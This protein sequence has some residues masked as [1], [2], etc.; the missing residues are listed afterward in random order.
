MALCGSPPLSG[1]AGHLVWT[2]AM[3]A[4]TAA[5]C[6]SLFPAAAAAAA[7]Y[8]NVMLNHLFGSVAQ[9]KCCQASLTTRDILTVLF[10]C[11]LSTVSAS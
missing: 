11:S 10:F 9:C 2:P 7:A 5:E 1:A 8:V 3:R 6:C 4:P